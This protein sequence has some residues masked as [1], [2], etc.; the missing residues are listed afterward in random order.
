MR[1]ILNRSPR[2]VGM[3]YDKA[4]KLDCPKNSLGKGMVISG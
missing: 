3:T 1:P 4:K 2:M